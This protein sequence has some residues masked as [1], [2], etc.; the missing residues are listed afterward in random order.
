MDRLGGAHVAASP[1]QTS[2]RVRIC[3]GSFRYAGPAPLPLEHATGGEQCSSQRSGSPPPP[4]RNN[5]NSP[6]P[7]GINR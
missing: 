2:V 3:S 1:S 4:I 6:F 7:V 5:I